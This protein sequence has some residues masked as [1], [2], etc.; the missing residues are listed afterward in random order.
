MF[1]MIR[2]AAPIAPITTM[3]LGTLAAAAFAAAAL[4]LF[5]NQDMSVIVLVW[6]VGT[7]AVLS[8]AGALTGK[9]FLRWPTWAG[10]RAT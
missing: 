2:R 8:V 7:V 1:W 10:R 6:Q 4:R 9:Y 5:H 3:G